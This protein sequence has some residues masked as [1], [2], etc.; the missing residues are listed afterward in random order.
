MVFLRTTQKTSIDLQIARSQALSWSRMH[1]MCSCPRALSIVIPAYNEEQR[2]K[3]TLESIFD[4]FSSKKNTDFEI[5]VADNGSKDNTRSVV[6]NFS[7]R[8]GNVFLT[9]PRP[10]FGKGFS[11]RQGMLANCSDKALFMDADGSAPI[12]EFE[13]LNEALENNFDVAIGSRAKSGA[14]IVVH[15]PFYRQLMGRTFNFFTK[16]ITGLDIEDTQCGFKAFT[17]NAASN[18]FVR[19]KIDGFA[20]DVEVLYLAKKLGY[21]IAEIPISWKNV[22]GSKVSPLFDAADMFL[23]IL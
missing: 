2:I 6:E 9:P 3:P 21:K 20:F 23:D 17:K 1:R 8:Y 11:I 15:Q 14:N 13:K 10:N 16:H 7:Y 22:E 5:I 19:Q 18:I 4:Y 12:S